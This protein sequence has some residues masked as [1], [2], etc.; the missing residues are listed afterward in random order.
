MRVGVFQ[1]EAFQVE[2]IIRMEVCSGI[3]RIEG[4]E[5][6]LC[7]AQGHVGGTEL[8]DV[9]RMAGGESE[10]KSAVDDVFSQSQGDV[11]DAVFR[12]LLADGVEVE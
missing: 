8:E 3:V 9:A 10:G 12:F 4:V 6:A 7:L 1:V 2:G 5:D 11:G